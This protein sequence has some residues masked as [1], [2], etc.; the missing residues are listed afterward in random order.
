VPE[1]HQELRHDERPANVE[2]AS[3]SD[4]EASEGSHVPPRLKTLRG[5]LDPREMGRLSGKARRARA[6]ER[7]EHRRQ[8][9]LTVRQRLGVA[10]QAELTVEDW[11]GV[12]GAARAAGNVS[13]LARLADQAFGRPQDAEPEE[14]ED[15]GLSALSREQ[16]AVLLEM[17][18]DATEFALEEDGET[19]MKLA[20]SART[21]RAAPPAAGESIPP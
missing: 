9:A 15:L 3:A 14:P 5:G 4:P 2:Q 12:I 10:L 20:G 21:Q 11:R 6:A 8:D 17:L 18:D 19:P 1:H 7:E 16:L 13:A